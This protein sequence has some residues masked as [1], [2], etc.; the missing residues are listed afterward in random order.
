MCV[1]SSGIESSF[2]GKPRVI[3]I[4]CIIFGDSGTY[5]GNK[6]G[7]VSMERGGRVWQRRDCG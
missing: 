4:A 7:D 2:N 1:V 6:Q 5:V 3:A